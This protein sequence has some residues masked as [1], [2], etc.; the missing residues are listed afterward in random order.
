MRL[1]RDVSRLPSRFRCLAR[2]RTPGGI[3]PELATWPRKCVTIRV[4]PYLHCVRKEPRTVPI[5]PSSLP[6]PHSHVSGLPAAFFLAH[7]CQGWT[8]CVCPPRFTSKCWPP[9]R[10]GLGHVEMRSGGWSPQGGISALIRRGGA[11]ALS[12]PCEDCKPGREPP[13]GTQACGFP[14]L[15]PPASRPEKSVSVG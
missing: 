2:V 8:E 3:R 1:I 10:W 14:E 11:Y 6:N 9:V 12:L 7:V 15:R 4:G 13:A 5:L